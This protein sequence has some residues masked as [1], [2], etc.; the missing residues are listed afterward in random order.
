MDRTSKFT[1][2]SAL[3]PP[4][5]KRQST[6]LLVSSG[7]NAYSRDNWFSE[8]FDQRANHQISFRVARCF[9]AVR[10]SIRR[11]LSLNHIFG[12]SVRPMWQIFE[13]YNNSSR[14]AEHERWLRQERRDWGHIGSGEPIA[15]PL[16]ARSYSL[17]ISPT[18]RKP[19]FEAVALQALFTL[20][21]GL[22]L[23]G[24]TT[25]RI[26]GIALV[27]FWGGA[28]VLIWRRPQLPTRTDI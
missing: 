24:G 12:I 26:C 23:D 27:A 16:D 18:Y 13:R 1:N 14:H 22:I 4:S 5:A 28:A 10:R 3:K 20:L 15:R 2:H 19:I 17:P 11:A 25:A 8:K 7:A 6:V 9:P 21:S